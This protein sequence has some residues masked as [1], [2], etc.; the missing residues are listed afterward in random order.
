MNDKHSG[1]GGSYINN[2]DGVREL[3]HRT[4]TVPVEGGEKLQPIGDASGVGEREAAE[5]KR[6]NGK[7]KEKGS[8]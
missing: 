3:V 7:G 1:M 4:G 2:D 6:E 8:E 5:A